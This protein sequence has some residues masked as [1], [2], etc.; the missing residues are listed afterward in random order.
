MDLCSSGLEID[1]EHSEELGDPL[2]GVRQGKVDDLCGVPRKVPSETFGDHK[3][4]NKPRSA[5]GLD[6]WE[7]LKISE[8]EEGLLSLKKRGIHNVVPS[9]PVSPLIA[10]WSPQADVAP[11]LK[12]MKAALDSPC[13]R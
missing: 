9:S 1:L 8:D 5:L 7:K 12:T 6:P 13:V 2:L 10:C 4:L 11:R 3:W